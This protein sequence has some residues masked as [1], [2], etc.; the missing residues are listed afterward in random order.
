MNWE[1]KEGGCKGLADYGN[2]VK[3]QKKVKKLKQLEGM[4][5]TER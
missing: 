2:E 3:R 4:N 5:N 1:E